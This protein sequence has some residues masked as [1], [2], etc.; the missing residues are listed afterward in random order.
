LSHFL[1]ER[2]ADGDHHTCTTTVPHQRCIGGSLNIA[3]VSVVNATLLYGNYTGNKK[4]T[5]VMVKMDG[6]EEAIAVAR[7]KLKIVAKGAEE[8]HLSV[9]DQERLQN[10]EEVRT[11]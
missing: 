9:R 1:D 7:N 11:I 8:P 4:G 10:G 2:Q 6:L 3:D 5:R